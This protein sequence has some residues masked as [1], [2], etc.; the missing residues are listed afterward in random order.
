[1]K[2]HRNISRRDRKAN[3][4]HAW[5]VRLQ[6]CSDI[7]HRMFS[8]SVHGG[9]R[10]ALKAALE[11][12]DTHLLQCSPIEHQIWIRT[13]LRK[14]NSSGIPGVGRYE[15]PAKQRTGGRQGYWLASWVNEN[16]ASRK[17]KFAVSLYG[18]RQAKRLAIAERVRQ[19]NLVC[20]IKAGRT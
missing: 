9:K 6:R 20:A 1:M 8:D 17:R 4:T 7:V 16:G 14:N 15:R 19:L 5:L 13:R 10:K 18:E 12:R 11:Y 3:H 2:R